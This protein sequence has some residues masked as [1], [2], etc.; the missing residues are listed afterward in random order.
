MFYLLWIHSQKWSLGLEPD[1]MTSFFFFKISLYIWK[2]KL[3]KEKE[4]EK[5]REGARERRERGEERHKRSRE[6]MTDHLSA[7]SCPKWPGWTQVK[8]K[9]LEFHLHLPREWEGPKHSGCPPLL[10]QVNLQEVELKVEQP[11]IEAVLILNKLLPSQ[12]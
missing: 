5:R 8:Y 11:G 10:S 3:E 4:V 7:G 12:A 1:I 6:L 2:T 9:R